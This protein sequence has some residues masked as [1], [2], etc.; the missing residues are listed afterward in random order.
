MRVQ[1][2]ESAADLLDLHCG[3]DGDPVVGAVAFLNAQV[4]IQQV[5]IE[6][7]QDQLRL[8]EIPDDP[9]HFVAVDIDDRVVHLDLGHRCGPCVAEEEESGAI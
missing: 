2:V 9:G 8:D 1:Y 6:V 4:V 3:I 7:G 5:D